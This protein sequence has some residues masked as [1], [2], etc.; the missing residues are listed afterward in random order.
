MLSDSKLRRPI[1]VVY[2][3][4]T[5]QEMLMMSLSENTSPAAMQDPPEEEIEWA[6]NYLGAEGRPLWYDVCD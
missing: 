5:K 6:R 3:R 2:D 4:T 1:H